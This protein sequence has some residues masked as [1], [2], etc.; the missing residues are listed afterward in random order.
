MPPI[1]DIKPKSAPYSPQPL[2][3]FYR[4]YSRE[5]DRHHRDHRDQLTL[6]LPPLAIRRHTGGSELIELND[7]Y[8]TDGAESVD[9][10]RPVTKGLSSLLN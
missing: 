8:A 2:P 1:P 5:G 7:Q 9:E 10:P 3:G 4:Q 6:S